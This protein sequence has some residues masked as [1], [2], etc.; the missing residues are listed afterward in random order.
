MNSTDRPPNLVRTGHSRRFLEV[1]LRLCRARRGPPAN[2]QG[3]KHAIFLLEKSRL[4]QFAPDGELPPV[5]FVP[6]HG[7]GASRRLGTGDESR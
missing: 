7:A 1:T 5:P 3:R 2:G 6:E 4:L